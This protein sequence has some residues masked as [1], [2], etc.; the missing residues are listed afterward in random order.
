MSGRKSRNKG[1]RG[2]RELFALLEE[3]LGRVVHRNLSQT[4]DAGCDTLSIPGFAV[5]VKRQEC[6]YKPA[7][8]QQAV[9]A[10]KAGHELPVV[11]FRRSRHPWRAAFR[12]SDLLKC[13]AYTG[14][15]IIELDDACTVI[16]EHL[17]HG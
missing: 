12:M 4:R 7:W 11:F 8:M 13:A 6:E 1:A 9:S 3:R 2:E 17:P 15:A 16:R 14:V 5:E 10:T